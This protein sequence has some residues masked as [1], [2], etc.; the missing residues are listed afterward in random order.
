MTY[1]IYLDMDGV[2][3]D[4]DGAAREF[5][6][7]AQLRPGYRKTK[8]EDALMW[9]KLK[10]VP[11]FYDRLEPMDGALEMYRNITE[12]FP[13]NVEILTGIPKPKRGLTTAG[14]DKINWAHR[15]LSSDLKVNIVYR[16]QKTDFCTGPESILIDDFE[17]NIELW[18]SA[19]G[20]G[21]LHVSPEKTLEE[22]FSLTGVN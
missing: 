16:E 6:G 21:I 14:E 13:G 2:L 18:R 9:T 1:K 22:L 3:A 11:H 12:C 19:G 4:F 17:D 5:C 20:T 8:E 7:L 10:E 15:Y